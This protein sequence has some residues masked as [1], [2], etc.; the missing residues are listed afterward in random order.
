MATPEMAY[1]CF[2][3]LCNKMDSN[4]QVVRPEFPDVK[5]PLFVTWNIAS[6]RGYDLRGCIGTFSPGLIH[7]L[8]PDY[9][10]TSA[11]EDTRF[12]PISNRELP[13]LQCAVSLLVKFEPG[14][15]CYDWEIG[16]HGIR[17][18]FMGK[19]MRYSAT[20]LPEVCPEQGWSK[21]ECL[22]SLIRKPGYRGPI[23]K[24][25]LS[26]I[27]L[28]RYQSSKVAVTWDDYCKWRESLQMS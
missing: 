17:I 10:L 19:G 2:D 4:H 26:G 21:E 23:T 22:E 8:L 18:S 7:K 9:A 1:L 20:Y 3:T 11:L 25:L 15:D 6:R 13:S 24:E 28:E 27:E 14:R 5:C 12:E 16:T